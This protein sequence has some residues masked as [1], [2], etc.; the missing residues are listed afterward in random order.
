MK[1]VSKK[2]LSLLLVVFLLAAAVP[3]QVFA[4]EAETT[5]ATTA[6]TAETEP[7]PAAD[8]A[9]ATYTLTL[10]AN[11]GLIGNNSTA[12]R[13]VTAGQV[14]GTL[15]T[16]TR[17][18]Y[19]FEGW[20]A[21]D[22]TRVEAGTVYNFGADLTISAKW[23]LNTKRLDVKRVLSSALSGATT[24][25][26]Q[27]VSQSQRLLD[28]LNTNVK[29][30]AEASVPAGYSWDG[31]WRDYA[32]NILTAQDVTMT[33]AQTVYVNYT[34]NNY[35]LYFNVDG[36]K[37]DPTSKTVTYDQK[38]GDLPTPT[39]DKQVFLGWF[40]EAG[41]KYTADTVYRVAGNTTLYAKWQDE[42]F[43][44]LRI[45]V[46]GDTASVDRIMD[47]TQYVENDNITRDAVEKIIKKY[48]SAQSGKS[49]SLAGLFTDSTW[50]D[51]RANT[52]KVG[53]PTVQIK[54][55]SPTYIYVMVNNAKQ[56]GSSSSNNGSNNGS[57]SGSSGSNNN[58][59]KP[60]DPTN[61]KT[62][63]TSP[64]YAMTIVMLVAA[65]ALVTVQYIRKRERA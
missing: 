4:D 6:D 22:G 26:E 47:M 7:A 30:T 43:V 28:Y 5:E 35:T 17:D 64:I 55:D 45:Y 58:T 37:V 29:A 59:T 54:T 48:Y 39:K 20:F 62:G 65:S 42:A 41:N 21:A 57:N 50:S 60:A 32:L 46:N 56:G 27:D 18:G 14:V 16:P 44:L 8:P 38:V 2:L 34:A 53:T 11:G 52:S 36:G 63:D 1:T 12:T 13:Q 31:Y 25:Y 49:L 33:Q 51:Y 40:D 19:T 61:P 10:D 24:I 9:P 3:F 23:A 15:E